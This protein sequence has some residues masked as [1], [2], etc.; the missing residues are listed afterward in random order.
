MLISMVVSF[1]IV[2]MLKSISPHEIS[3]IAKGI[4]NRI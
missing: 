4:I 1:S 2:I 3:Q